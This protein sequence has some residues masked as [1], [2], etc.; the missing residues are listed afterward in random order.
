[1]QQE[2]YSS[3]QAFVKTPSL[4][5]SAQSSASDD[6]ANKQNMQKLLAKCVS[7]S[8]FFGFISPGLFIT[9]FKM[10][11]ET[12]SMGGESSWLE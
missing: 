4:A 6:Q 3:L 1:L 9:F 7:C 12:W 5:N 2:A 11:P 8:L 10:L